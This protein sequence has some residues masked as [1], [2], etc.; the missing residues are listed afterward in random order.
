MLATWLSLLSSAATIEHAKH[1]GDPSW[2]PTCITN[3]SS[4]TAR[5]TRSTPTGGFEPIPCS[6]HRTHGAGA[7]PGATGAWNL[8]AAYTY[9]L[10]RGLVGELINELKGQTVIEFGSGMGCYLGSMRDSKAFAR[11]DGF[12][13]AP[14]IGKLTSGLVKHADLTKDLSLGCADIVLCLE[15]AEHIPATFESTLLSNLNRHNAKG[16]ILSWSEH[17]GGLGHVNPRPASYVEQR[18]KGLGYV[19]NVTATHK[20][21]RAVKDVSWL[22]RTVARYDRSG[23]GGCIAR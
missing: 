2:R 20:L 11:V 10:D 5:C 18:L 23:G 17:T 8:T 21:R 16:L 19:L 14:G 3:P 9:Y 15:V 1:L 6:G 22:K 13:G 4:R 7:D 12:D